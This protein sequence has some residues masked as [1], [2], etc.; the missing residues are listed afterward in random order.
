MTRL[1]RQHWTAQLLLDLDRTAP[2]ID[3]MTYHMLSETCFVAPQIAP[4]DMPGFAAAGITT[5]ICNR[6]DAEVPSEL[7]SG[8]L[9]AAAEAAGLVF[10]DNPSVAGGMTMQDVTDQA[11]LLADSEGK[12]LA[13]CASGTRS[14]VLWALA[15]A[16][17]LPTEDIL[18]ATE[19]AGYA[20]QGLRGQ[21][22]MLAAQK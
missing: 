7:S 17:A 22:D 2:Y 3:R 19:R 18:A 5:I 14:A 1:R 9:R 8:V 10:H 21:I 15:T 16:G 13:Y 20:L 12:V 11:A 4:T 6:P